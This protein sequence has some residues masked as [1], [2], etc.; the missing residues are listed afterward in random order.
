MSSTLR[1][2]TLLSTLLLAGC[3]G[4]KLEDFTGRSP[5]LALEQYFDGRL[6]AHGFFQDRFGKVRRQ[7]TVDI[8]GRREGRTLVLTEDFVYDDGEKERR[9]WRLEP[10]A[11]PGEWQGHAEGVIG[12]A[13]GRT[14]GNAFNWQYDFAL[15]V[16]GRRMNVHFDDWLWLQGDGVLINRATVSKLGVTLG[17]VTIAFVKPQ[18]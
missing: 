14:S 7:F 12:I 3:A 18:T 10:G 4:L 2:L 15:P 11:A 17:E 6:R 1:T 5:A 8:E 9:I 16:G 13:R